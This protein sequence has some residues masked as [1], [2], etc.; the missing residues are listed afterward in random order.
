MKAWNIKV[1]SNT[2]EIVKKLNSTFR[3]GNGFVFIMG[4]DDKDSVTFKMR[5]RVLYAY[6]IIVNNKIIVNGKMLKTNT[7]NE[8]DVEIHFTQHFLITLWV[9]VYLGFGLFATILGITSSSAMYIVG[10][11]LLAVGLAL[12]IDVHK[13]FKRSIQKY[14]TLISEVLEL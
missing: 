8:T 5:K 7:E 12:W 4:H 14:K 3:P 10:G 6:Q 9:S 11:I 2:Q 1:K 13:R